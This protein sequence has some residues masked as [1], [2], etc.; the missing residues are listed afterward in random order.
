[1]N[2]NRQLCIVVLMTLC[3]IPIL[4]QLNGTGFY[5]FR[6]AARPTEYIS[7]TND[8]FNYWNIIDD[9][10]GGLE[11]L[12]NE[13]AAQQRSVT[14]SIRFLQN[15]IHMVE[16]PNIIDLASVIYAKEITTDNEYNLIGQGT[17]LLTLTTGIYKGTYTLVLFPVPITLNFE[18]LYVSLRPV[19]EAEGKIRYTASMALKASNFSQADLG[20]RYFVDEGGKFDNDEYSSPEATPIK[21]KW[22]IEPVDYFNVQ[23][24][25][26][27]NGKYYTT[28]KVP[29]AVNLSGSV[30]KAY[31][32][33]AISDGVIVY[34]EI[35]GT[36]SAG[37]PVLLQCSSPNAA[38]C[39]IIP[40]G[41]PVFTAPQETTHTSTTGVPAATD[42][43]APTND[44][45][46]IGTYYCNTDGTLS[47]PTASGNSTINGNHYQSI[48]GKYELGITADGKFGFVQAKGIT[49]PQGIHA[50]PANKAW[51][52]STG[53]FP[54]VATPSI[55][56]A[57][58]SYA[59]V[60]TVTITAEEGTTILYSTDNGSTWNE[61]VSAIEIGEGTTTISA[62][63]IKA[64]PYN[65]SEV[66]TAVYVVEIPV[67]IVLGDVN[68]D[69]I[70]N[71]ADVTKLIDYL[72]GNSATPFNRNNADVK[73][74]GNIDI[75]DVTS[76]I[77]MLLNNPATE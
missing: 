10:G 1:M 63:A 77:D 34:R 30:E 40:M 46:L 29:F 31:A 59:E 8:R 13:S 12:A 5:R 61:Y 26:E 57:S 52:N 64:G 56:P 27:Y 42:V 36:I 21:A 28:L 74:D 41:E 65:D 25:V 16:D 15:D 66:A 24:E 11:P 45:L 47:Y 54:T 44:N 22:Y 67:T 58:G 70:V 23:P 2:K 35:T 51:M 76:L 6:N 17:S 20:I 68:D 55:T 19:D 69:G 38:D 32:I 7:M 18:D 53:L 50:M 49:T 14:C 3:T 72:L 62:K 33:T 37:T 48:N 75:A 73:Q 39:R 4:A 60:Q 43:I 9:A 71:I